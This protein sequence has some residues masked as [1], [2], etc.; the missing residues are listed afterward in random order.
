M[1]QT[2]FY[3]AIVEGIMTKE[4]TD[5]LDSHRWGNSM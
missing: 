5:L 1:D 2:N 3:V 4:C